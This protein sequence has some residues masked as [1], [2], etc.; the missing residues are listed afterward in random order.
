M[1]TKR[2]LTKQQVIDLMGIFT[3]EPNMPVMPDW[4][5]IPYCD[6]WAGAIGYDNYDLLTDWSKPSDC[7]VCVD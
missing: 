3:P 5:G 6:E 2:N 4:R 1:W 7:V